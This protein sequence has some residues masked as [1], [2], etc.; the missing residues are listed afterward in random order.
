MQNRPRRNTG[1]IVNVFKPPEDA[2]KIYGIVRTSKVSS[3]LLTI[4][5]VLVGKDLVPEGITS[6]I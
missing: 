3:C 6:S 2:V 5:V 1:T 4:D